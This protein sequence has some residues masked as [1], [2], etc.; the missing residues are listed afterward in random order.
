[1]RDAEHYRMA[2]ALVVR[3]AAGPLV[4]LGGLVVVLGVIA[5]ALGWSRLIVVLGAAV[6]LLTVAG[7]AAWL[8]WGVALVTLDAAGYRVR[9]LRHLGPRTGA[10]ADVREVTAERPGGVP[11]LH[12]YRHDGQETVVPV[13]LLD[14]DR[15]RFAEAVVA[16]LR[17]A[18]PTDSSPSDAA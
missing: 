9:F 13:V 14:A 5:A 11:C 18:A 8:S 16:R 7:F 2:P 3:L 12:L 10:W 1:M 15:D 4:L 17:A 6:G